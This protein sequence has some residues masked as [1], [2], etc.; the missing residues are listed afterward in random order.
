MSQPMPGGRRRIDRVLADDF[1][2]DLAGLDVDEVRGRRAEADQEETDL[3]FMRRMLQ[4]RMDLLVAEQRRRAAGEELPPLV[5]RLT[6]ALAS[7]GPRVTTGSG[8]HQE[9]DPSRLGEYRR[10]PER[11]A[12]TIAFSDPSSL[13][14]EAIVAA[15]ARLRTQEEETSELRRRVQAVADTLHAELGRRVA[16]GTV[17]AQDLIP[18]S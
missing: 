15:L 9:M 4:G 7:D 18:G 6:A 14:D 1:C 16:E 12:G 3:S 2:V 17:A 11:L 10:T 8:R 5:D 13:S